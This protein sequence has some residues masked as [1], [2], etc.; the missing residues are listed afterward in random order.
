MN[1][2][3]DKEHHLCRTKVLYLGTKNYV[4][5]DDTDG[6]NFQINLKLIQDTIA[7]R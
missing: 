3:N 2:P 1:L 5:N 7:C 4:N 6:G